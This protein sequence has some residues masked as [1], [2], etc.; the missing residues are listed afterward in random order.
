MV[1]YYFIVAICIL[2]ATNSLF[3]QVKKPVPMRSDTVAAGTN[4]CAGADVVSC[5]VTVISNMII[6]TNVYKL[7][8]GCIEGSANFKPQTLIYFE[9]IISSPRPGVLVKQP[10]LKVYVQ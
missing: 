7:N 10:P 2:T 6:M 5:R 3:S 4:I 9:D 1:R 8:G